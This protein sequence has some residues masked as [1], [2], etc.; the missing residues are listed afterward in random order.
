M[1]VV[2][3]AD[4]IDKT[5]RGRRV[6]TSASLRACH[7]QITGLLG[8]NGTGKT[9]LL[10]IAAG[11]VA[12]DHGTLR[13][14]NEVVDQPTLHGLAAR[15]L[16]FLP[17]DQSLLSPSHTVEEHLR[18]VA[19]QFGQRN[20]RLG[21]DEDVDLVRLLD[22]PA[23]A[24]SGGERRRVQL[25]MVRLRAPQCLLADEPFRDL[26]PK[27]ADFIV[28]ELRRLAAEGCAIVLTGHETTFVFRAI[29]EVTW[30]TSGTTRILGSPAQAEADSTFR[31][32]FLG[33]WRSRVNPVGELHVRT[34]A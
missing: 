33:S 17:A 3:V 10:R 29:D 14:R 8:R 15:G 13:F 31:Q 2:L 5:F 9:T 6:L 24:L 32:E 7:G 20:W 28:A 22:N 25:A 26:A 16:F 21:I 23:R 27:D 1:N 30:V 11:L 12:A 19:R 18:G 4:S 34:P